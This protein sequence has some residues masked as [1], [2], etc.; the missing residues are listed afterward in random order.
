MTK[1]ILSKKN[2]IGYGFSTFIFPEI[3]QLGISTMMNNLPPWQLRPRFLFS[4]NL[5]AEENEFLVEKKLKIFEKGGIETLKKLMKVVKEKRK[6][7]RG[8]QVMQ[9]NSIHLE[10]PRVLLPFL[11]IFSLNGMDWRDGGILSL[12]PYCATLYFRVPQ[13]TKWVYF[14]FFNS[15]FFHCSLLIDFHGIRRKCVCGGILPPFSTFSGD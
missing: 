14:V 4:Q 10:K 7:E 8:A 12:P 11:G 5:T 1:R 2:N 6:K 9:L 13:G 15:F 3:L